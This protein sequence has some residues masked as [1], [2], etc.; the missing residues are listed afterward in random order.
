MIVY[1]DTSALMKLYVEEAH[2]DAAA[3]A[4]S[5]VDAVATSM[6]AYPET[7]AALAR[8]R[9]DRRL[10]SSD[11]RRVLAQF[12]QD[13]ASYV[14]LDTHHSL[15]LHDGELA[16]HHALRGADAVHL[17]SAI[18]LAHDLRSSPESIAFLAFDVPLARAAA[19]EY[20]TLH[21]LNPKS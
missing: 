4:M 10:R 9:R 14:L 13:W 17:A 11:F 21:V 6:L 18:Q 12:Q 15:M 3:N 19:R 1:C 8:A 5:A 20:L 7:R 16:E 2:S